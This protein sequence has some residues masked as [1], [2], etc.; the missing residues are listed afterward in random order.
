MAEAVAFLAPA[1]LLMTVAAAAATLALPDR[2]RRHGVLAGVQVGAVG[3]LAA[4]FW[5]LIGGEAGSWLSLAMVAVSFV[6][7]LFVDA[8]LVVAMAAAASVVLSRARPNV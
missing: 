8:A 3:L 4:A 7:S 6:A 5:R 1:T 2:S